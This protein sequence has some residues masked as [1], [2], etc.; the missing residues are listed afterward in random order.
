MPTWETHIEIAKRV[1]KHLKLNNEEKEEYLLANLLPD[2]NCAYAIKDVS[3]VIDHKYT[4]Y[5]NFLE[6][7]IQNKKYM[8]EITTFGYFSHLF[9]DYIWNSNFYTKK[10]KDFD[11][12]K[13]TKDEL[14]FLKQND[15]RF[16]NNLYSNNSIKIKDLNKFVAKI[17]NLNR[18]SL[19]TKDLEKTLSYINNNEYVIDN[20]ELN[21]YT[22]EELENLC[23]E[24][25]AKILEFKEKIIDKN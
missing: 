18:I 15:F 17:K 8:N 13:F 10:I 16:Y 19:N 9:S 23:N 14:R 11:I 24:T 20:I 22:K 2:I 5:N 6:F 3:K 25:V 1:A 4:H 21:F 12:S 7:Y